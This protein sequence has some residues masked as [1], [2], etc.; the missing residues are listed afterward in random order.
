[1]AIDTLKRNLIEAECRYKVAVQNLRGTMQRKQVIYKTVN[2]SAPSNVASYRI[3]G[4]AQ[5]NEDRGIAAVKPLRGVIEVDRCALECLDALADLTHV[6]LLHHHAYSDRQCK[7]VSDEP[8]PFKP[9]SDVGECRNDSLDK[10]K[11]AH[12]ECFERKGVIKRLV[13]GMSGGADSTLALLL[14]C[15]LRDRYGYDVTAVHCIH[16]LD[17]D[18]DIWLSNNIAVCKQLGVE[19]KTPVLNIVYGNGVSPEEVSRNER[20]RE[21]ISEASSEHDA[22]VF[23]HQADD[24]TE[25]FL[26]A[27]KRGSGPQGLG[28]MS[29]IREDERGLIIRPLLMLHKVEVEQILV[30]SAIPYVY[31]LSNSYLKFERNFMRLKVLPLMRSRFAG[32]DKA[33]L[34]SQSLCAA[35]HDLAE[36]FI[37]SQIALYLIRVSEYPYY[38][39]DY[40]KLDLTDRNLSTMLLRSFFNKYLKISVELNIIE[41]CL[42]LMI[43]PNDSNGLIKLNA[44]GPFSQDLVIS[45][46]AQ[47]LYLY[48]HD[49]LET[50]FKDQQSSNVCIDGLGYKLDVGSKILIGSYEYALHEHGDDKNVDA[51]DK[52]NAQDVIAPNELLVNEPSELERIELESYGD[53]LFLDFGYTGSLKLKPL[54]RSHSREVKKIFMERGVAPWQRRRQPIIVDS[55]GNKLALGTVCLL[56]TSSIRYEQDSRLALRK[57]TLTIKRRI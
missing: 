16:R 25:S 51:I 32:V 24:Q 2:S 31:D 45:T 15:Q 37:D 28:G 22:L 5:D 43:R 14:S 55:N 34:R 1:M 39:F 10:C 47:H 21:L 3:L 52:R 42:E 7:D 49:P 27:L 19:L 56:D 6:Q 20:Y 26:L 13:T 36:R 40:S 41:Q 35:E 8:L 38:G 33:I 11:L 46:F 30:S 17:P 53:C 54:K 18:D 12:C 57:L 4:N 44:L 50:S 23:G 9:L 48:E 29:F